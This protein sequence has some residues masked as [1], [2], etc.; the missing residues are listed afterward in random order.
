MDALEFLEKGGKTWKKPIYVVAGDE[1]FLKRRTIAALQTLILGEGDPAFALSTYPGD[2]AE[3]ASV[4]GELDTLP[5][6]CE[7][8]LVIIEQADTFVTKYRASLEKYVDAPATHGVLILEVKSW[9]KTTIL[10]KKVP[11][12]STLHCKAPPVYKLAAWCTAWAQ[13]QYGKKLP[14]PAANLLVELVGAQMGV[15]DSEID[16]LAVFA[17]GRSTIEQAD[18]DALVGRSRSANVFKIMDAIGDG[19][20][21]EALKILSELFEAGE[22]TIGILGALG[23]QIRKI[24]AA[25]RLHKLG[26]GMDDALTRADVAA[27][28]QA[29]DAARKQMK[30]LGWNRL[31]SLYDWLIETD[32]GMKGGNPLP[33]Q[34]QMERLIVRL[35]RPPVARK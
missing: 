28:P 9:V 4:R 35:A 2:K 7:Y 11:E 17:G 19:K 18:V 21:D 30:H 34:V 33:E 16:K 3:F 10:A 31:D 14:A 27:W 23:F 20:P 5:F 13:K 6:L 29:R 1:E 26:A 25:A 24:A 12:A 22:S 32:L 15:L 8:R